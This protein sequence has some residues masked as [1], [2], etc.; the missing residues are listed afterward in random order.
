MSHKYCDTVDQINLNSTL[1]LSTHTHSLTERVVMPL[2]SGAPLSQEAQEEEDE[3]F[4][5]PP[6][7]GNIYDKVDRPEP[8]YE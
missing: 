6:H 8:E 5:E 3:D 2:G 1:C 4:E 7:R